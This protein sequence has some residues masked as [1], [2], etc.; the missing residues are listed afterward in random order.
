VIGQLRPW[1]AERR[2]SPS[3]GTAHGWVYSPAATQTLPGLT[4]SAAIDST[5]SSFQSLKEVKS[6]SGTQCPAAASHRYA[7]PMSVRA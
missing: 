1:A 7:P 4:G 6:I 3:S 2:I 5:P